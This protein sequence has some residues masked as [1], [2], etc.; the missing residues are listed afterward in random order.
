MSVH[1]YKNKSSMYDYN[2]FIL[3]SDNI[4]CFYVY[5]YIFIDPFLH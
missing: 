1:K 2:P 4:E 5:L 3:P